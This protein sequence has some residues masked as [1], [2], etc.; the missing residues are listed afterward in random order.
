VGPIPS[1]V[2]PWD[3]N[4]SPVIPVGG[5]LAGIT[6]SEDSEEE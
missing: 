1:I 5:E 6:D 2:H 4:F 3:L